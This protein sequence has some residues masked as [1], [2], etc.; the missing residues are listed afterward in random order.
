MLKN[1]F[2]HFLLLVNILLINNCSSNNSKINLSIGN[3]RD[4]ILLDK[5][6]KLLV[7]NDTLFF[8]DVLYSIDRK[9]I[10]ENVF[11][12]KDSILVK[13]NSNINEINKSLFLDNKPVR[14]EF[15]N[16]YI[17]AI[18]VTNFRKGFRGQDF[19]S[20]L[21]FFMQDGSVNKV[22]YPQQENRQIFDITLFKDSLVI[23][24]ETESKSGQFITRFF[25][26]SS[27]IE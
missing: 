17:K 25:P 20:K 11:F 23:V 12:L 24:S 4:S 3:A 10:I 27:V 5:A 15:D 6:Y 8:I 18:T 9:P 26:L 21:V 13:V 7:K 2:Y 19:G 22:V 14:L 16:K 1:I